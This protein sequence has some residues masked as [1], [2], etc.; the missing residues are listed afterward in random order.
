M[1]YE[2]IR[3]NEALILHY[4]GLPSSR[5][6]DSL[7]NLCSRFEFTYVKGWKVERLK[8]EDQ[9]LM[10]LMKLRKNLNHLDLSHRFRVSDTCVGNVVTTWIHLLHEVLFQGMLVGNGIPSVLKNQSSM[11]SCFSSFS[12]CRIILDCTEVQCAI[13]S[14]MEHQC[15]TYSNYKKRNTHKALVGVAP[16]G[17]YHLCE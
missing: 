6:F 10:T 17:G 14:T 8:P 15:A 7:L 2:E 3:E 5:E 16:N 11:P 13:P 1:T 4:T 12:S 9:L